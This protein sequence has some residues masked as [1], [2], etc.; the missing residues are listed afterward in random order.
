MTGQPAQLTVM[1]RGNG[2]QDGQIVASIIGGVVSELNQQFNVTAQVSQALAGK[3]I[4]PR[5]LLSRHCNSWTG[6]SNT[7]SWGLKR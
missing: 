7:R 1:Q 5:K 6:N 3:N 4:P 2:G